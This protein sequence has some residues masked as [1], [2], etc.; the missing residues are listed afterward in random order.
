[1]N[2]HTVISVGLGVEK[3]NVKP[4]VISPLENICVYEKSI[5]FYDK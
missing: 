1:M 3:L 2:I 5:S 4:V